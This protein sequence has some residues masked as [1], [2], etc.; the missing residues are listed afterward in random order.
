MRKK[1]KVD[2]K[3][4]GGEEKGEK[5]ASHLPKKEATG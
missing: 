4:P 3:S 1:G 2:E 5:P